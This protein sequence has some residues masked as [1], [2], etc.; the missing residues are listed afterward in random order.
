MR[1]VRHWFYLRLRINFCSR[2]PPTKNVSWPFSAG[3]ARHCF[4][5][6]L[7]YTLSLFERLANF[8][9]D[10]DSY[11]NGQFASALSNRPPGDRPATLAMA[12]NFRREVILDGDRHRITPPAIVE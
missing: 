8:T 9:H 4:S 11:S 3:A 5:K 1:R 10:A 7:F 12:P 6:P 2:A